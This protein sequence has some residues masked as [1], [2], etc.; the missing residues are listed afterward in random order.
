[1]KTGIKTLK[2]GVES[3]IRRIGGYITLDGAAETEMK[4]SEIEVVKDTGLYAKVTAKGNFSD[5]A[6]GEI[7][8][9][10][11]SGTPESRN[12]VQNHSENRPEYLQHGH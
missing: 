10:L 3:Y 6:R 7:T 8:V 5:F 11:A 12:R 1:M 4:V 2:S 9:T